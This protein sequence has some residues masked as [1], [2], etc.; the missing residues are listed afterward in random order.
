MFNVGSVCKGFTA[1][2]IACLV[3]DG[4]VNW[5]DQIDHFLNGLPATRNGEFTIRDL[6]SHRT[7]LCR[8]DALFIGSDNRLLLTKNQGTDIFACLDASR[9]PRQDFIYNNSGYHAVGCVIEKVS[10]MEYGDFLAQ[11]IF[12]P[13]NMNRTFTKLPPLSDKNVSQAYV[14]CSNLQLRPV[15]SPRIS[16]DTLAF[17]AGSIRSS[18]T[19]LLTF[20][21]ALLRIPPHLYPRA[22]STIS[23]PFSQSYG[24]GWART[25]LPNQI[26]ELSGNSGLLDTYPT[27]GDATQAPLVLHHGGNNLG[28]SSAV[29]MMPELQC[30]IVVLGNALGHCDATDW[31]AQVLTE[32]YLCGGIRTPFSHYAEIAATQGRSAMDRVQEMLDKERIPSDPPDD[33]EQYTGIFGTKQAIF[34]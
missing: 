15:P 16:T 12:K 24:M 22:S 14:P 1:L 17:A 26:S 29:Y 32:A 18:M 34:A 6:L 30:G 19:D 7:G 5:H 25:Q 4:K 11:R 21:G 2:A 10:S 27:I 13:L 3:A 9:P 28:C 8:S 20:Y 23:I 33:L 31:A